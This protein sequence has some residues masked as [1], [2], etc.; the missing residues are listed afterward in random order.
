MKKLY[1]HLAV[2][3]GVAFGGM[4]AMLSLIKFGLSNVATIVFFAGTVGAVLNNY[5]RLSKLASMPRTA[6]LDTRLVAL[7]MYVSMLIGGILAWVMYGL[8]V[9]GLVEGALFP[10]FDPDRTLA[11]YDKLEGFLPALRPMTNVDVAKSILWGFISG[12]SERLI[13]NFIDRLGQKEQA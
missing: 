13:P 6:D 4:A 1:W 5:Y 3:A 10:K 11:M 12:F 2:T 7:Q 9:S 8:C